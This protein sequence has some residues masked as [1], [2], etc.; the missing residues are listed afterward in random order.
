MKIRINKNSI[1]LRL[2]QNEVNTYI[3]S[4]KIYSACDFVNG[5]LIYELNQSDSNQVTAN[6]TANKIVVSLPSKL[7]KSWDIDD[8]VGFDGTDTNGLYI[9]VEKD[10][11]CLKPRLHEDESDLF[12]NPQSIDFNV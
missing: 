12:P 7:I 8:R 5:Q 4:G 1:R 9:L 3:K 6:M 2:S 11:Q 10:F